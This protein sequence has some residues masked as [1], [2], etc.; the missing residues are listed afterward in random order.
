MAS[1]NKE[2]D[3][4]ISKITDI[5]KIDKRVV[6]AICRSSLKFTADVLRNPDDIRPIRHRYFGVFAMRTYCKKKKLS[7]NSNTNCNKEI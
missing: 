4:L 6:D 7:E 3:V 2:H 1:R 5:V